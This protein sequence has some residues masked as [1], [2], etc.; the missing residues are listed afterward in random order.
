MKINSEKPIK[1]QTPPAAGLNRSGK[2]PVLLTDKIAETLLSTPEEWYVIGSSD[3][4]IS[5]VK[6]NIENMTQ[7]N[8]T[9]LKDKGVFEIKQR[10]NTDT[11]QV[12]IYCRFVPSVF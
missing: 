11:G 9:H 12:D 6:S 4:W 1:R 7:K 3:K 10:R 2:Q 8:I 5:G